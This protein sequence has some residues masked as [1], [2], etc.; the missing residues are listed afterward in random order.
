MQVATMT[1]NVHNAKDNNT[2]ISFFNL[3]Y[4]P[5][6]YVCMQGATMIYNVHNA[7]DNNAD[8]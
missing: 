6:W 4:G 5:N 3:V 8:N 2:N 1:Y 7:K